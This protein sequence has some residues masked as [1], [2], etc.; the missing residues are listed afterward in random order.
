MSL[1][2]VY[3]RATVGVDAPL[4]SVEVHLAN[5][6][7]AFNLVGLPEA[8]VRES[9]DRVRSALI[10]AGFEFPAKRITVNLAPADLP[11]EGGRFDLAIA[12][13]I[14]IA[15]GNLP[16]DSAS[17]VEF[18]GELALSGTIRPVTA[19][20]P[21]AF[22]CTQAGHKGIIPTEN[23]AEA[24]LLADARILLAGHLTEVFHHLAGQVQLPLAPP[25]E[26]P[27]PAHTSADLTDVVGQTGAKRALEI[28][29]AGGHNLL[30]L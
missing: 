22:A 5:G 4:I 23:Q 14:I 9:K 11:K 19:A 20:L 21:F 18:I 3:S 6:L 17:N 26:A 25:T 10:N 29:A 16:A 27:I 24:A 2:V 12:I 7:P 13:G 30:S 1:A 8:S 28:A 15:N